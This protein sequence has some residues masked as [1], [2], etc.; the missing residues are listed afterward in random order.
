MLAVHMAVPFDLDTGQAI[1]YTLLSTTPI[2]VYHL[3]SMLIPT[4]PQEAHTLAREFLQCPSIP[5]SPFQRR[6]PCNHWKKT[7]RKPRVRMRTS[8]DTML[9]DQLTPGLSSGSPSRLV[10][11]SS[12]P[13]GR[14]S[15]G[16]I[17]C[18]VPPG[19]RPLAWPSKLRTQGLES[20]STWTLFPLAYTTTPLGA[21][22]TKS[23]C[24][25][26]SV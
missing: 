17:K 25:R 26:I 1:T 22:Q 6:V 24:L 21:W 13:L 3:S 11:A 8:V 18:V 9:H 16:S 14:C 12:V 20:V 7:K 15:S 4:S 2:L 19:T 23:T 10:V 5:C